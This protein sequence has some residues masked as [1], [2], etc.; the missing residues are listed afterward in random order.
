MEINVFI[1]RL[2]NRDKWA[3][4][5]FMTHLPHQWAL[6]TFP[7]VGV[8]AVVGSC[9]LKYWLTDYGTS[10]IEMCFMMNHRAKKLSTNISLWNQRRLTNMR[11]VSRWSYRTVHTELSRMSSGSL[12]QTKWIWFIIIIRWIEFF[13]QKRVCRLGF[14]LTRIEFRFKDFWQN[15]KLSTDFILFILISINPLSEIV[16]FLFLT[17]AVL[18]LAQHTVLLPWL[19]FKLVSILQLK[20]PTLYSSLTRF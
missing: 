3:N 4:T 8:F 13:S 2:N 11:R 16:I 18:V 19:G 9:R 10:C 6:N 12:Q 17:G 1:L 5:D 14:C 15:L 7:P 20:D